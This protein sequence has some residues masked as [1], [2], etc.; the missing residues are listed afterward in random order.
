ML[1]Q[2]LIERDPAGRPMVQVVENPTSKKPRTFENRARGLRVPHFGST[3]LILL[4]EY[5]SDRDFH[6]DLIEVANSGLSPL[7]ENE[8]DR[9]SRE[10]LS[11]LRTGGAEAAM[12]TLDAQPGGL[13]VI[14]LR[15][16]STD[17]R[18]F[19]I[20]RDGVAHSSRPTTIV[21]ALRDAFS[22]LPLT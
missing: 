7:E 13:V 15:L 11:A 4:A 2:V 1:S 20:R 6:I 18:S 19:S 3:D 14:G 5:F 21:S 22:S 16:T 12:R 9:V 17:L 10:M 8:E